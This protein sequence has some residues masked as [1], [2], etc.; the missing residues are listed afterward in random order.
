MLPR[1]EAWP[2]RRP[3]AAPP[4]AGRPG[5]KGERMTLDPARPCVACRTEASLPAGT[6]VTPSVH[7][8]VCVGCGARIL[9]AA[10]SRELVA[11]GVAQPV[12]LA[13]VPKGDLVPIMTVDQLREMQKFRQ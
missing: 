2:D 6:V 12:C 5:R 7:P 11:I 3:R 10:S 8:G 1:L 13:C 4:P 9:L